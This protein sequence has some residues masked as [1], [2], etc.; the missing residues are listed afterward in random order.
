MRY[1]RFLLGAPAPAHRLLTPH[2]ISS[3]APDSTTLRPS[4]RLQLTAYYSHIL[5]STGL[6]TAATT[7]QQ[8]EN[9]AHNEQIHQ[10]RSDRRGID[11]RRVMTAALYMA[12][13]LARAV[14][15]QREREWKRVALL[16][17]A[18]QHPTLQDVLGG[19][20]QTLSARARTRGRRLLYGSK[21]ATRAAV[22]TNRMMS[23]I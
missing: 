11:L 9:S 4:T 17:L 6:I 22:T 12:M 15:G 19:A 3:L 7:R 8:H 14:F 21:A 23:P 5:V 16:A 13:S 10:R 20:P 18:G 1:P 2:Y